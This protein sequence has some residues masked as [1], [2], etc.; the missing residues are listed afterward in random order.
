[1]AHGA[2][3]L[4]AVIVGVAPPF[5]LIVI[6]AAGVEAQ[7]AADRAHDAMRRTRDL[8]CGLRHHGIM[9]AHLRVLGEFGERH[10][11]ADL[12]PVRIGFDRAQLGDIIHL[13]QD[14]RRDDA[15]PDVDRE[16]GAAAERP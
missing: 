14:R 15:A 12:D 7:I 3:G 5:A 9:R 1:M 6:D 16:I 8:V 11:G 10:R 13:D 4:E 2:G